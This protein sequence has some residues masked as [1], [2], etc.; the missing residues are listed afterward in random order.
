MRSRSAGSTR[1]TGA[2][3]SISSTST[4]RRRRPSD[5]RRAMNSDDL[6][7]V[8]ATYGSRAYRSLKTSGVESALALFYRAT[9][10]MTRVGG[11]K[12]RSRSNRRK[13]APRQSSLRG[14]VAGEGGYP[15]QG[16]GA[17]VVLRTDAT[18][19]TRLHGEV[20]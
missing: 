15:H 7:A 2:G 20:R 11:S 12:R 16:H 19:Q 18:R 4:R 1:A 9:S 14:A 3:T 13:A 6:A 5:P 8:S 17:A 10:P